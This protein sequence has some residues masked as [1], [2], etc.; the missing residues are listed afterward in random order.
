GAK[1]APPADL[2]QRLADP[3]NVAAGEKLVRK[4]GCPGCHDI[5]GMESESRI[6][7]ELTSFGGKT[8]EELFFGDRTD[9][10]ETWDVWT[11]HKLKE[12]RGYETKWIEQV[13]PQFDLADEDV[14]AL[15]VFLASRTEHKVPAKY[16]PKTAGEKEIVDGRRLVARYNCTGCHIIEGRGGDIRR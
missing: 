9:I 1:Q 12:P 6:G 10:R 2:E 7:A 16:K 11:F 8:H 14:L 4:F 5:P 13:M 15:K 3:A